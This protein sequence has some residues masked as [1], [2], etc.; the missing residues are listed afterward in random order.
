MYIE[1][2]LGTIILCCI[3]IIAKY[4]REY[5]KIDN[6]YGK[7]YKAR[8]VKLVGTHPEIRSGIYSMAIHPNEAISLNQRVIMY[9]QIKSLEIVERVEKGE[10]NRHY[11]DLLLQDDYGENQLCL[12]SK[13][14]FVDIANELQRAWLRSKIC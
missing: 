2:L 4:S 5:R 12:T 11:L 13:T 9:S 7:P 6:H 14:E 8:L 1:V 3:I 10:H